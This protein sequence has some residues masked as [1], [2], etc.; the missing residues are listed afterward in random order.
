M[1]KSTKKDAR[2]ARRIR[3]QGAKHRRIE[4][5]LVAEGVGSAS[6][7]ETVPSGSPPQ[8]FA[9]RNE[10]FSRL[11]S[12]GGRPALEGAV[13]RQKIP[14]TDADWDRLNQIAKALSSED[15][16]PSPSQVA[17]TILHRW[18][19]DFVED[20]DPAVLGSLKGA[21]LAERSGGGGKSPA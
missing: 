2:S 9:V 21:A 15:Y 19:A 14:L 4:P 17:S 1:K 18:L 10:L 12:S 8:L 3:N 6:R 7:A 5:G 13:R 20:A 11:V 16:R